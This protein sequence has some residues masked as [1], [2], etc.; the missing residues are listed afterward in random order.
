MQKLPDFVSTVSHHLKPFLRDGSQL[1]C[2][3]FHP[4][5]DGR[6][7]LDG[8]VQSKQFCSRSHGV[9][10]LPPVATGAVLFPGE[11]FELTPQQD[12]TWKEQVVYQFPGQSPAPGMAI[13]AADGRFYGMT[14]DGGRTILAQCFV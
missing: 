12:G 11:I 4:A 2:M 6:I 9:L 1:T 8:A 10:E 13:F 5:I 7:T 14:F 3:L